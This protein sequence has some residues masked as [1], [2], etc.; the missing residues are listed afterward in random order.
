MTPSQ[1][2]AF[3][4][5]AQPYYLALRAAMTAFGIKTP[6]QVAMFLGQVAH[7]SAGFTRLEENLN[8][9]AE[10]LLATWPKR[11]NE[12]QARAYAM[13]P[14]R[15]ANRAY[16]N[17]LGNGDEASGHGWRYRGRG[18]IQLTGLDNYG[19]CSKA[20]SPKPGYLLRNPET[21]LRPLFAA[22]SAAWFWRA[23]KCNDPADAGSLE[24]VTR[25]INGGL[26][27]LA[28]RRIWWEKAQHAL[29]A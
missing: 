16:A 15:I 6:A 19:W 11:F 25:R 5:A 10:A 2:S 14:E 9:S 13:Q 3:C 29:H 21:L 12:A 28:D 26:T 7:E 23:K 4:P 20:L 27:G 22:E 8:Y 24:E 18:L 17:R 1:L